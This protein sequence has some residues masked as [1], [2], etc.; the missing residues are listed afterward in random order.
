MLGGLAAGIAMGTKPV[1]V[2]FVVPLLLIF[3]GAIGVQ[4]RS[5]GRTLAAVLPALGC[6]LLTSGFWYGRNVLLTGN[7]LYPLHLELFG[8][9][10]LR[11]WYGRDAMQFSP[12]T[13]R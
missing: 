13:C 2:V 1:G 12:T 6:T 9:T 10:I 4:A 11:G 5:V 3:I 7:P 8:R